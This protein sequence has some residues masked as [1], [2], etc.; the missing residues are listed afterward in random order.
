MYAS[1]SLEMTLPAA[2]M[3]WVLTVTPGRTVARAPTQAPSSMTIGLT[4]RPKAGSVQSW[5]P[6][7]K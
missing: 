6:V 1:A 3:A 2:M 5:L 4:I 7:Q